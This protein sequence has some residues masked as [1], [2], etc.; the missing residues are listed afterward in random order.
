M[1][2]PSWI[3]VR[4]LDSLSS[5]FLAI[6]TYPMEGDVQKD[7]PREIL[8]DLVPDELI[9]PNSEFD[10]LFNNEGEVLGIRKS[11]RG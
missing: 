6:E 9:S 2:L 3:H 5:G 8:L 4:V 11:Q 1:S 10:V 7:I